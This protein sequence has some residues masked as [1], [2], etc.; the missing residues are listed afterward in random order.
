MATALSSAPAE[1]RA[2]LS[3]LYD[4][5]ADL[6]ERDGGKKLATTGQVRNTYANSLEYGLQNTGIVGKYPGLAEAVEST[7]AK[8][9]S[10]DNKTIDA[11]LAKKIA[12]GF[13]EVAAQCR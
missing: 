10:L 13:R 5:M 8:H 11:D 2:R 9:Y 6:V 3:L 4:A 1:D 7:L 12:A